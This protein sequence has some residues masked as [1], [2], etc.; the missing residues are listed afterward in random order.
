MYGSKSSKALDK[1]ISLDPGNYKAHLAKGIS[2]AKTPALFGGSLDKAL[3]LFKK[4]LELSPKSEDV[5]VW[6]GVVYRMKGK[7]KE[8]EKVLTDIID[9]NPDNH[10][11]RRELKKTKNY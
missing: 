3:E 10:W 2:K 4:A 8:S 1:A 11:A 7:I 6:I 5:R 9:Q